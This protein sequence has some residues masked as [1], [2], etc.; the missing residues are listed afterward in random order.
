[1]F[2]CVLNTLLQKACVNDLHKHSHKKFLVTMTQVKLDLEKLE[3]LLKRPFYPKGWEKCIYYLV[4][5]E[6]IILWYYLHYL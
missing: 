5:V 1:M 6:N 3:T 4:M 2:D